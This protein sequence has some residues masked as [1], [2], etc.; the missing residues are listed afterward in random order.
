MYLSFVSLALLFSRVSSQNTLH[1]VSSVFHYACLLA[2]FLALISALC[3]AFSYL[4]RACFFTCR[5]ILRPC[6]VSPPPPTFLVCIWIIHALSNVVFPFLHYTHSYVSCYVP[7]LS[8]WLLTVSRKS[9]CSQYG[10]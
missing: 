4:N 8:S 10:Q 5:L 2:V 3:G 9:L 1:F 7:S 6:P